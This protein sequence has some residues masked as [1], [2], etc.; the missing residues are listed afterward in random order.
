M[1]PDEIKELRQ[2]VVALVSAAGDDLPAEL[3]DS[4]WSEIV[5]E[6]AAEATTLLFEE[7]GR[8][9]ARSSILDGVV[10][11]RLGHEVA[12]GVAY[13]LDHADVD[14]QRAVLLA[15]PTAG[16]RIVLVQP[17][18]AWAFDLDAA[19]PAPI[20]SFDLTR[21]WTVVRIPTS[22]RTPVDAPAAEAV[23]AGRRALAAELIGNASE[24]LRLAM[25]Y[26]S[27]RHQY[28]HPLAA[29]Q[30]VRHRYADCYVAIDA[31]RALLRTAFR[32]GTPFAAV[33]A[34]AA[35]GRAARR[36]A[37]DALQTFGAIGST[38]EHVLHRYVAR[39]AALDGLLGSSNELLLE[40]G[41]AVLAAEPSPVL[42][43]I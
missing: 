3:V 27:D 17:D 25:E 31:A 32:N 43:E 30:S 9:L 33:A 2:T 11:D 16:S 8:L 39:S 20:E 23:A 19:E 7:H 40:L 18:G 26:A 22:A 41:D 24:M 5:A 37:T 38:R 14:S 4:G 35:A 12:D 36:T 10:L 28:G 29:F 42:T 1:T 13:P 21:G 34:K 15:P 6:D